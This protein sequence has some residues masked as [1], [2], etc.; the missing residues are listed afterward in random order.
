M[1]HDTAKLR[2]VSIDRS[3]TGSSWNHS[4]TTAHTSD[5]IDTTK[6]AVM[7]GLPNQSSSCPLSS[8][9]SR[10]PRPNPMSRMPR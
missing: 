4:H 5:T 10:H 3:T 6:N 8:T 7:N 1:P 2:S 9:T